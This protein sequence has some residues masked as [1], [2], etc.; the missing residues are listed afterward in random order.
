[1]KVEYTLDITGELCPMTLVKTKLMLE[2]LAP[3]DLLMIRLRG[4]EA[5]RNVPQSLKDHG[6]EVLEERTLEDGCCSVIV[7]KYER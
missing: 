3:G 7:R 5:R 1:M 2:K 4:A 6:Y